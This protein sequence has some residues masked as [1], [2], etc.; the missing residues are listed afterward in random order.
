MFPACVSVA[1]IWKASPVLISALIFPY[2]L[3]YW[4][5][6]AVSQGRLSV[7]LHVVASCY[8]VVRCPRLVRGRDLG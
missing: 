8:T 1:S 7:S 3:G 4:R 2:L 5:W 6:G